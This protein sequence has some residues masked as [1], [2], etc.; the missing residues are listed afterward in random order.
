MARPNITSRTVREA[1]PESGLRSPQGD[2]AVRYVGVKGSSSAAIAA[3]ALSDTLAEGGKA[4]TNWMAE[5]EQRGA[6]EAAHDRSKGIEKNPEYA[7]SPSAT[8]GNGESDKRGPKSRGYMK[9]WA[10]LDGMSDVARARQ[11]IPNRLSQRNFDEMSM[12][13]ARVAIDEE[14]RADFGGADQD[15]EYTRHVAA[16]LVE[17]QET[18]L[19]GKREQLQ[20]LEKQEKVQRI[21][22]FALEEFT[23]TG[24]FPHEAVN[25]MAREMFDGEERAAVHATVVGNAAIDAK[26]ETIIEG[27]PDKYSSGAPTRKRELAETQDKV[28]RERI[29]D[30]AMDET[31]I[32]SET[33]VGLAKTAMVGALDRAEARRR[34]TPDADGL[35]LISEGEY[36]QLL[37]MDHNARMEEQTGGLHLAAVWGG[38]AQSLT[39]REY[40]ESLLELSSR[41]PEEARDA[42]MI[43]RNASNGRMHGSH[44]RFMDNADPNNPEAFE[45]GLQLFNLYQDQRAGFASEHVSA[46]ALRRFET[47]QVLSERM[48]PEKALQRMQD[49]GYDPKLV[50]EIKGAPYREAVDSAVKKQRDLPWTIREAEESPLLQR[51]IRRE[52]EYGVGLGLTLE[53][54]TELAVQRVA[55]TTIEI[56][57]HFHR[58]NVGFDGTAK[59][60]VTFYKEQTYG[61]NA[62]D[63]DMVPIPNGGGAVYFIQR[64]DLLLSDPTAVDPGEIT[65]SWHVESE[66]RALEAATVGQEKRHDKLRDDRLKSIVPPQAWP[67]HIDGPAGHELDRVAREEYWNALTPKQQTDLMTI[68]IAEDNERKRRNAER[69]S[70]PDPIFAPS[71][72]RT[73]ATR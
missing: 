43:E 25:E 11:A 40:E 12:D 58:T 36:Q 32:R 28:R 14:I 17:I 49:G 33:Y 29:A 65:R 61:E 27:M 26:D 35:S 42:F 24:V 2:V 64:G 9:A 54:A 34:A 55:Q 62:E 22:D 8:F 3:E 18:L 37:L 53:Q 60:A 51:L 4:V 5:R 48:G 6:I 63:Y 21:S 57:G 44:K 15:P 31:T 45:R 50:D 68:W 39:D 73:R 71:T 30:R 20:L 47:F 56:D 69:D 10:R 16:G 1:T 19:A 41:L 67:P 59:D 7:D 13:E 38:S 66:R 46:D 23:R 52:V 72:P 70:Q